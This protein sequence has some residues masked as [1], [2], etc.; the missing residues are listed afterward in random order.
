MPAWRSLELGSSGPAFLPQFPE[1]I[2]VAVK[3]AAFYKFVA[4]EDPAGLQAVLRDACE[5][6]G[7][8]GT[9]LIAPEG[10]NGTVS[11]ADGEIDALLSAVRA[12]GR[13]AELAV[14]FSQA[15]E[16]PFQRLKVKVKREIV[17]FGVPEAEPA[18]ETGELVEPEDWNALISDPDVVVIDTRNDYEVQ[19][20]TFEGARNPHTQAFNEFPDY[21]RH[22]LSQDR[23][24]RI[25]MFC[26]GG[27]RCEKASAFLLQEG[28]AQVYQLKGGILRYLERIA[29]EESLWRGECFVFDERVALEHGVRQGH[30]GL[31][32]RCG[33]PIKRDDESADALCSR[34]AELRHGEG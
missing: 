1:T 11:G 7:I 9:I 14:K 33:F 34:C 8:K 5:A 22:T 12:D 17:T 23:S 20:G 4:I 28:F 15:A 21:V 10:I 29:P 18:V 31:C 25:A 32:S 16:P 26:T 2:H 3:V 19:V 13:F 27:I 30:H 24:R 6:H